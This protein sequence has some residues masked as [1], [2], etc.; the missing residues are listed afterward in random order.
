MNKF[1]FLIITVFI[2]T[3][4]S[5][6][7]KN[8]REMMTNPNVNYFELCKAYDAYW[9][10]K[11]KTKGSGHKQFERWRS[12]VEPYVNKD[13]SI[14]SYKEVWEK[15]T[16]YHKLQTSRS[17]NGNFIEIGPFEEHNYSRGVGR[18]TVI[19]FHPKD[20]NTLYVGSPSGGLW[21]SNDNG[22]TWTTPNDDIMTFGVSA[23]A[24]DSKSPNT[25]YIGTG[26][27]DTRGTGGTGVYKSI[28]AGKTWIRKNLGM[29]D[30]VVTKL[31]I[32]PDSSNILIAA[33]KAG[34]FKT[35][36]SA[37]TWQKVIANGDFRD[38]E[39]KP[40]KS[41]V[42]YASKW[43]Y[44]GISSFIYVSKDKG[45][46]WKMLFIPEGLYPDM[47]NELDVTAANPDLLYGLGEKRLVVTANEGDTFTTVNSVGKFLLDRDEQG[48]YNACF[49]IDLDNEKIMYA[50]NRQ[51][52]KTYDGGLSWVRLNHTHADNHYI[53]IHPIT[54]ELYVLDDGGIHRSKD[55]GNTFED[56]TNLGVAAI[57]SV[58]Q[59]PFNTDQVLNGY[60]DCGS[61]F[62]NG[63]SW[64]STYGADGMQSLFDATDSMIFYTA[65]QYGGIVR[66]L[67]HV[68]SPQ[69][70]E[71]PKDEGPWETPY[72]LD[73]FDNQTMYCGRQTVWK[74]TNVH[75]KDRK[76]VTWT[77]IGT[78][79]A[80]N[81]GRYIQ[82]K[83]HETN[84][85]RMYA[86]TQVADRS[87]SSLIVC[88]NIYASSP[89]WRNLSLAFPSS[90]YLADV[91]TDPFDSLA[92]YVTVGSTIYESKDGGVKFSNATQNLPDVPY[93]VLEIDTV[94]GNLY[95]GG[96]AGVFC[97]I[98]GDTIWKSF[99]NGLSASAHARDMDIYY[100]PGNH[101][102]S[103]IKVATYGRGL[104]ESDLIGSGTPS[105]PVSSAYIRSANSN[106]SFDKDFEITVSFRKHVNIDSVIG[107]TTT[108][109]QVRNGVVN[110]IKNNGREF[111]VNISA[112]SF[113]FVYVDIPKA[114]ATSAINGTAT[115][116]SLTFR[117][118]YIPEPVQLGPFGPG[119]VGDSTSLML[120][121]KGD[122][123]MTDKKGDT[124][125]TDGE[126]INNWYDI[127]GKGFYGEQ[128]VD[129]SQPKLRLDSNGISGWPA[130]EYN[131]PN[132]FLSINEFGPVGN[133]IT[134]FALAKSNTVNWTGTSWIANARE[135]NGFFI[136]P[137][138][139]SKTCTGY[140]A[141]NSKR[142]LGTPS[143]DMPSITEPH[144]YSISYN[145]RMW[146]N[147][148]Y[149]DDRTAVDFLTS[150]H[151]RNGNDTINIR[152]G[153]DTK[154]RYG[155]GL[156]AEMIYYK[157]DIGETKRLLVANYLAAKY[158]VNLKSDKR[159]NWDTSFYYDVAGIGRIS[160]IDYHPDAKGSIVRINSASSLDDNDFL[161]WGHN[162]DS[163]KWDSV[164]TG[165]GRLNNR[166]WHVSEKGNTGSVTVN[167]DSADFGETAK[168][169]GVKVGSLTDLKGTTS[170]RIITMS[171]NNGVYSVVLDLSD[172]EYFT[173]ITGE[174]LFLG[175]ETYSFLNS[176][177]LVPNPS[178]NGT[179]EIRFHSPEVSDIVV[180]VLDYSGKIIMEKEFDAKLGTNS[181]PLNLVNQATGI[182]FVLIRSEHGE[183]ALKLVR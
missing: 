38:L 49:K 173:F 110:S 168:E 64:K 69:V 34:I 134:V 10:G 154:T 50:G 107:F 124:L 57:Y 79:V 180:S 18:L 97:R 175:N 120:W 11:E 5:G 179:S 116:S 135:K 86:L 149:V 133:D 111:I 35:V 75:I 108:D 105:A 62:Y 98:K 51:L 63:Y 24:I 132:R 164:S 36:D 181:I 161:M 59:S 61:K 7:T 99:S 176:A 60:Q 1:L 92:I 131:P 4:L 162:N 37:N 53:D 159:Y 23:I 31:L 121:M 103:K 6:Q 127:S 41:S 66:Y 84:P 68:G 157:E 102:D 29:D 47:R 3:N 117:I 119:G 16:S 169:V 44:P 138:N 26:D 21:I 160:A 55:G 32:D 54:K 78:G 12:S 144:I 115:D 141:D 122:N 114:A 43:T 129:S 167:V 22:K 28:D 118:D 9:K 145:E 152:L 143:V 146:K 58:A 140:V 13:G 72:I 126:R 30:M 96:D 87:K 123:V 14:G 76:K 174:D 171:L 19:A 25:I 125:T 73:Y 139:D 142:N 151:Y 88:D 109:V 77:S 82:I 89:V 17:V 83:L 74:S 8:W 27:A 178:A 100:S 91:E 95:A 156:L 45:S 136:H 155:D 112:S 81:V 48:W 104:W 52:Y 42:V 130:V 147:H 137:N 153:K 90:N 170:G 172:D 94:N 93:H 71:H 182:Y 15:A 148:F 85:N 166:T 183:K 106:H 65:Y 46:T 2:S 150:D 40:G 33:T 20:V 67:K 101:S 163:I 80:A 70:I 165:N 113:G 39:F 56:L 177:R 158:K 128:G